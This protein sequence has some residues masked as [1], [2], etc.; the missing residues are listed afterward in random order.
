MYICQKLM[1]KNIC[2]ILT[3]VNAWQIVVPSRHLINKWMMKDHKQH[4]V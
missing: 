1:Y 3:Y 2:A 4:T